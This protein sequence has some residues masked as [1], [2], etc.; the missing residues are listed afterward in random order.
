VSDPLI[1]AALDHLARTSPHTVILY[2]SRARGD[3]TDASDVD[4][5]AFADGLAPT[6]DATTLAPGVL[7]DAWLYPT[8]ALRMPPEGLG[9]EPGEYLKYLDARCLRDE[10]GLGAAL[11]AEV[12]RR[13]AAGPPALPAD[14]RRHLIAWV[15]KM[16]ARARRDDLEGRYRAGWLRTDLLRIYFELRAQWYLGPKRALTWLAAHDPGVHAQL[17]A[18]YAAPSD[19]DQLEALARAVVR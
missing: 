1:A 3:H 4:L 11:L 9:P 15:H 6:K 16:C 19:L 10:R 12:T 17:D 2:G 7:L 13:A 14:A 18:S 8:E 5:S